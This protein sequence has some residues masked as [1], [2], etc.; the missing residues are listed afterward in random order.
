MMGYGILKPFIGYGS[1]TWTLFYCLKNI[2]LTKKLLVDGLD[3]L[4]GARRMVDWLQQ[5]LDAQPPA[6]A[7]MT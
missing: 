6:F 1:S 2:Q 5:P 3:P 7:T 4:K